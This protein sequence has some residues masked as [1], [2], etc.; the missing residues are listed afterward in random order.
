MTLEN[1]LFLDAQKKFNDEFK[2]QIEELGCKLSY[3]VTKVGGSIAIDAIVQYKDE[4]SE[5]TMEQA[6]KIIPQ[7][8]KYTDPKESNRTHYFPVKTTH[9]RIPV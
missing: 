9:G 3:G 6:E 7:V 5:K 4:I 2:P 1:D 8:Y